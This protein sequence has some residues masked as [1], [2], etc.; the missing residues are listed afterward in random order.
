MLSRYSSTL[1]Q[2][3]TDLADLA[4]YLASV[5]GVQTGPDL[6]QQG[7]TGSRNEAAQSGQGFEI[8]FIPTSSPRGRACCRARGS[9][10]TR[11][12]QAEPTI[13]AGTR[14][15]GRRGKRCRECGRHDL[16]EH[17]RQF[18][19]AAVNQ[20]RRRGEEV[21]C[22][23]TLC[24]GA[25]STTR[26]PTAAAAAVSIPDDASHS[27]RHGAV[28]CRE[29]DECRLRVY[30]GLVRPGDIG[31]RLRVPGRTP[32]APVVFFAWYTYAPSGQA[33]G[34][35]GQRWF[36]GLGTFTPGTHT[37]PLTLYETTGGVF[38]TSDADSAGHRRRRHSNTSPS[39]AARPHN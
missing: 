31:T 18:R 25:R 20:P 3:Q 2:N 1:A 7:L 13:S 26:S 24:T 8:Q 34:A 4:A 6:N 36:T 9:R 27:E 5:A 22:L 37:A 23:S 11:R 29:G 17:G 35:A 33:A 21:R 32:L 15:A 12:R 30:P 16:P 39:R 14:S 38:D 19:R 10:S 28:G